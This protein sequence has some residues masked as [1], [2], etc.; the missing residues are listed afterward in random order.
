MACTPQR[1]LSLTVATAPAVP[2]D[3]AY[4]GQRWRWLGLPGGQ[5]GRG[6][7]DKH[8]LRERMPSAVPV[9]ACG[10]SAQSPSSLN[11]AFPQFGLCGRR[12]SG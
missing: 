4:R 3:T 7:S 1:E 9:R 5:F 12:T 11:V 2:A 10:R 6:R 8:T